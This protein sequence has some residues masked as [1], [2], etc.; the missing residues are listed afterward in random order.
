[1]NRKTK[2]SEE[3]RLVVDTRSTSLPK[4]PFALRSPTKTCR[5]W[6]ETYQRVINDEAKSCRG[7]A[8]SLSHGYNPVNFAAG[9][10]P[11]PIP[12]K[13]IPCS[14]FCTRPRR[15]VFAGINCCFGV[16]LRLGRASQWTSA[17]IL[18]QQREKLHNQR[19]CN[20]AGSCNVEPNCESNDAEGAS[21]WCIASSNQKFQLSRGFQRCEKSIRERQEFLRITFERGAE[22]LKFDWEFNNWS[23]KCLQRISSYFLNFSIFKSTR[24]FLSVFVCLNF[25]FKLYDTILCTYSRTWLKK[26][27]I[28]Q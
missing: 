5:H 24:D 2:K 12:S 20:A 26:D 14:L 22:E 3:K 1:M 19:N 6:S 21:W 15:D 8:K 4:N 13:K 16:C 10:T 28:L 23:N 7:R 9:P 18:P 25:C 17:E 11:C 27:L